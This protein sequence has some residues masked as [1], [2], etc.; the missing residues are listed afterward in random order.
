MN[1]YPYTD[2]HELNLDWLLCEFKKLKGDYANFKD[3]FYEWLREYFEKYGIPD[4]LNA[5]RYSYTGT[6][7]ALYVY[8]AC[9]SGDDNNDG[10][11]ASTPVKTVKRALEI[12]ARYHND[13]RIEFVESGTYKWEP[14][15]ITAQAMHIHASA[16]GVVIESDRDIVF[17]NT[18]LNVLA[19][20][21]RPVRFTFNPE[22][23][24]TPR[25][26]FDGGQVNIANCTIDGLLRFN[27]C[28]AELT[29]CTFSHVSV[30]RGGTCQMIDCK[31][32]NPYADNIA[33]FDLQNGQM[34]L[35]NSF[36]ITATRNSNAHFINSIGSN[37]RCQVSLDN[38][39]NVTF[40]NGTRMI[41]GE[42][43]IPNAYYNQLKALGD[44]SLSTTMLTNIS[45]VGTVERLVGSY[46]PSVPTQ[47]VPIQT[48][49]LDPGSYVINATLVSQVAIPNDTNIVSV[50]HITQGN[51]SVS[52][53]D[54]KAS[55]RYQKN[56]SGLVNTAEP[57]DIEV[58][59]RYDG[60]S[61]SFSSD[62]KIMT[63][64]TY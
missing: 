6:A 55:S 52:R 48:I 11:S 5:E 29:N 12:G 16:A 22:F 20:E 4:A 32:K 23:S 44:V 47:Y 25:M 50:L 2:F 51:E 41:T 40:A 9:N 61:L 58:R 54:I 28:G 27:G 30:R 63:I 43:L 49:H 34:F 3:E 31:L 14:L 46:V 24:G 56:L 19:D 10:K 13:Y 38:P 26:Y 37:F 39:N 17:Y 21:T 8:I 64:R 60:E 35:Y 1:K 15:V 59:I 18:H 57:L 33:A 53:D 36:K 62:T 42:L 45:D 7:G